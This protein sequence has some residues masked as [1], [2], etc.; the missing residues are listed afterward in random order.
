KGLDYLGIVR[1][2]ITN[3]R[4]GR[5]SQGASTITQQVARSFLLTREKKLARKIKEAILASRIET[6][7]DKNHILY[8]YLNQ[9]Y[10]GHGAYG[11]QAA[12]QLYFGKDVS[13][14]DLAEAA[15]IAGLP[16]APA[17]YSPNRNF[18]AAKVRQKYVLGQMA[19]REYITQE[20]AEA[21]AQQ[22]LTFVRKRNRNLDIAPFYVEHVRRHL[23]KKYGHDATYN[24]GLQVTIPI[25][26]SL[27]KVANESVSQGVRFTDKRVGYRGPI[28]RYGDELSARQKALEA[29]DKERAVELR[30]YDPAFDLP[31]GPLARDLVPAFQKDE[32]TRGVVAEVG[33]TW[34]IVDVGSLRGLIPVS[35]FTWCHNI[36]PDVDFRYFK[37]RRL[38]DM[39]K[40]GDLIAV[41]VVETELEDWSRTLPRKHDST[42]KFVRLAM[43][44]APG[45]EGAL[46]SLRVADGAVLSMVG[47]SS[48]EGSE[49]NRAI[50][51]KRQVGSTFKPLVY[52]AA[53]DHEKKP[54]TPS[55]I[56]VDAPI[57]EELTGKEGELWKPGNS[58]GEY[59]GDTTF[60][61]GLILSR[62]IVTL[63]VLRAIGVSYTLD[64]MKRFGFETKLEENLAMGLGAS[65]LTIHELLRAYTVFATLGDRRE[66]FFISE[67]RD[68]H[69][70]VLEQTLEGELTADVLSEETAYV[71]V[72]LMRSVVKSGTAR[73]ALE[74]GHEVAGKTGTTNAF[75]DAWFVGYTP[76]ILTTAWVGFD[77][78][79]PLGK[80]QYGGEIAL[81]I[82]MRYMK[83]ALEKYPPSEYKEPKD[84]VVADIDSRTGL[85]ARE[86]EPAVKV[87]Y[88]KDTE[89]KTYAPSANQVDA[90][91]FL[92]GEY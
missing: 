72:D 82:W 38:D 1:A 71:M 18:R 78:F 20:Q 5:M 3:I 54:H 83:A 22:E 9:I 77:D 19:K 41:R 51:A 59:L 37:C 47:G 17:N 92:S 24:Q 33:R 61:R 55:T 53:L 32:I 66:P 30:P 50:Q 27:Q 11:V 80:G 4:E 70:T 63:K 29:I 45:P 57:V 86:G 60:R 64:Y 73:R 43:E 89:P 42:K 12:A 85:L 75:R 2:M 79:R 31:E 56:L 49:F 10:L 69:G 84:I 52:A 58:G 74:L 35:E 21:A 36:K 68:R 6:N 44:Q 13:Q 48:F 14:L 16:Q 40:V 7:F 76:E 8:L 91:D 25:D 26:V 39:V 28:E 46:M 34:A 15:I 90:A 65:A 23:I 88:K 87:V 62:N 81:P 67:V